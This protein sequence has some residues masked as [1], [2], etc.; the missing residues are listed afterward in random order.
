[1]KVSIIIPAFNEEK[2][3]LEVVKRVKKL[4][5]EKEII[6]VDDG[7]I[8][9]TADKL[10]KLK[11]NEIIIHTHS[12]NQGKGAAVR[13][14]LRKATGQIIVIQDADL[15]YCPEELCTLVKPIIRGEADVVYGSRFLREDRPDFGSYGIYYLGN[16]FLTHL[17]RVLFLTNI[18]DLNTCYKVFHKRSLRGIKLRANRFDLD[19]EITAKVLKRK[20][21]YMEFPITYKGRSHKEGK[22]ITWKDG[23][24]ASITLIRY[25]LFS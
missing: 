25:R 5:F 8:D 15:E 23:I 3:I 1:M 10:E 7:S 17:T 14:G 18:T 19:P 22:K 16:R 20:V 11:G 9:G 4:P 24:Q 13:T 21:R 6:I 12:K 2:T